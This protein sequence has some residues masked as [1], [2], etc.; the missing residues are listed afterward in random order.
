ME[1]Y[2]QE[3]VVRFAMVAGQDA[4]FISINTTKQ[5]KI[6]LRSMVDVLRQYFDMME[7]ELEGEEGGFVMESDDS[8]EGDLH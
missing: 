6:D 5:E 2:D 8:G 7:A 3:L 4:A 1:E